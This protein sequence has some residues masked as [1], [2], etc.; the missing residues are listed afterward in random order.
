MMGRVR[1]GGPSTRGNAHASGS[2]TGL[3]D[4]IRELVRRPRRAGG[5]GPRLRIRWGAVAGAGLTV[6]FLVW[7]LALSPLVGVREIAVAGVDGPDREVV[8]GI[9][10]QAKG[11][12]LVKVDT[13][14]IADEIIAL[15]TVAQVD[16][17]RHWPTTLVIRVKPR[18]AVFYLPNPE[19]GVQI[20]DADGVAFWNPQQPPAGVPEVTLQRADD[21]SQR[22]AAAAVVTSLSAAQRTRVKELRVSESARVTLN[23]GDVMVTWGGPERSDVKARIVEVLSRRQGVTSINVVVPD[24]PV[25]GGR[26]ASTP[27]P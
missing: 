7:L 18:E 15:G 4:R 5:P 12:P 17:E 13:D 3:G 23:I 9:G 16:V 19:G 20:F 26:S 14:R 11:D 21:P 8:A 2:G 22:R 24:S 27:K 6:L 25:T 1:R 10:Q